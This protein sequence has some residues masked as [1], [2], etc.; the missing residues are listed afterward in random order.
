[1]LAQAGDGDRVRG[2]FKYHGA[3]T[4]RWTAHGVQPQNL[5][6]PNGLD[7]APAIEL[8]AAG[9]YERIKQHYDNPL[10]VVGSVARAAI[11]AAPGHRLIAAD[12]SAASRAA[13][14]RGSPARVRS[15]SSGPTS[16][17]AATIRT[18][19]L[20]LRMG[21]PKDTARE[22]GKVADLAFGYM[23][24]VGAYRKFGDADAP[25]DDIKRLQ[26][27]WRERPSADGR[28]L[29]RA[30]SRGEARS[31]QAGGRCQGK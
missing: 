11:V 7:L 21:F 4:G 13:F 17:P 28:A 23:G 30:R 14:W 5:K 24:G 3:A 6:K 20:G 19:V 15:S 22:T 9:D 18:L 25:E 26:K 31:R 10:A 27:A 1:M 16:T 29:V 12:F 8:V 2:S